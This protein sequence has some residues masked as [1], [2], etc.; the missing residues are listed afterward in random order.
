MGGRIDP[1]CQV[2]M[3]KRIPAITK[4]GEIRFVGEF[5]NELI[6]FSHGK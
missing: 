6:S 3:R 2:G 5:D 1:L 4:P